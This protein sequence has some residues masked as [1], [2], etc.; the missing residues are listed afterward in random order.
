ME[1][2]ALIINI[3]F[4]NLTKDAESSTRK[5]LTVIEILKRG[6]YPAVD[7]VKAVTLYYKLFCFY[8]VQKILVL[9]P[10][11]RLEIEVYAVW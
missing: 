9:F 6:L 10:D 8:F 2:K 7:V 3:I 4:L 11:F 1:C 5:E